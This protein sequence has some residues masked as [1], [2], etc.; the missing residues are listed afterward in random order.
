VIGWHPKLLSKE[1][2]A[3]IEILIELLFKAFETVFDGLIPKK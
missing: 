1:E 3:E 2:L